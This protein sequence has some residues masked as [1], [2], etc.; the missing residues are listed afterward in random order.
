M[1]NRVQSYA[2]YW[3][4]PQKWVKNDNKTRANSWN[5]Q[6]DC[7]ANSFLEKGKV[8][9]IRLFYS[10]MSHYSSLTERRW[11]LLNTATSSWHSYT[12]LRIF[13]DKSSPKGG[14]FSDTLFPRDEYLKVSDSYMLAINHLHR[15]ISD[16]KPFL[17]NKRLSSAGHFS[18]KEHLFC[19]S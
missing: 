6:T 2:K 11:F 4:W 8:F 7:W 9:I 19:R 12:Y 13:S 1:N 18:E 5:R 10:Y 16:G 3:E 15:V 17:L 14:S